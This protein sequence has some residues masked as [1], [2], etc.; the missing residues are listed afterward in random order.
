MENVTVSFISSSLI[1]FMLVYQLVEF[2][3][4]YFYRIYVDV[5]FGGVDIHLSD[6]VNCE[7]ESFRDKKLSLLYRTSSPNNSLV[8]VTNKNAE[9]KSGTVSNGEI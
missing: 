8:T 3:R 7:I 5:T 2:L 9:M 1:F 6:Q 4:L